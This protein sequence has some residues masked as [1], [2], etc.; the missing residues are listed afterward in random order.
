VCQ[1]RPEGDEVKPQAKKKERK[2]EDK[3]SDNS[4][5]QLTKKSRSSKEKQA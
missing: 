2:R 3:N 4:D 1:L 5:D